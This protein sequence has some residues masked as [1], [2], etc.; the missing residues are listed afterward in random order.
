MVNGIALLVYYFD[1]GG[2]TEQIKVKIGVIVRD[3]CRRGVVCR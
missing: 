1:T 2:M 3:W